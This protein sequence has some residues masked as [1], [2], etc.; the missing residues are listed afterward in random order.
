MCEFHFK[1]AIHHITSDEEKRK[2]LINIFNNK[3]DLNKISK[4]NYS[5]KEIKSGIGLYYISKINNNNIDVKYKIINNLFIFKI[6][7]K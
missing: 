5:T 7:Y 2:H 6:I 4:K 3:I 1:Q